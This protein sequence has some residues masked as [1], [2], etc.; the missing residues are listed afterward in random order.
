MFSCVSDNPRSVKR[1]RIADVSLANPL[2]E[3]T[4]GGES[5]VRIVI[6]SVSSR[7]AHANY[8]AKIPDAVLLEAEAAAAVSVAHARTLII[9][10]LHLDYV[11]L[12][13]ATQDGSIET[14]APFSQ[15]SFDEL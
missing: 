1:L 11:R 8:A 15:K 4:D 10:Q 13:N 14:Q 2:A 7:R 6:A 3:M 12:E 5:A 9:T